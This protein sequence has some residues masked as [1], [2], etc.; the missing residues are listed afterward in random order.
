NERR[1]GSLSPHWFECHGH[2]YVISSA[3]FGGGAEPTYVVSEFG[4]LAI[5][6]LEDDGRGG[7]AI[8]LE[9]GDGGFEFGDSIALRCQGNGN[10][11]EGQRCQHRN[12]PVRA[13]AFTPD[14]VLT[15]LSH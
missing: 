1:G 3:E 15:E 5:E 14:H 11:G 9:R 10:A 13:K 7:F 6:T 2:R 12:T 8:G 4:E